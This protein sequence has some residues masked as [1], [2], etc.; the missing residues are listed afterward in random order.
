MEP[1]MIDRD[2]LLEYLCELEDC[3]NSKDCACYMNVTRVLDNIRKWIDE[4]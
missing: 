1:I 3:Y 4:N 2:E